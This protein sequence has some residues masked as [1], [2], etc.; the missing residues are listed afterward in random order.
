MWKYSSILKSFPKNF[1]YCSSLTTQHDIDTYQVTLI[2][3]FEILGQAS[4]QGV[5]PVT[6][7]HV[8]LAQSWMV[9]D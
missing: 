3:I 5:L 6:F 1:K 2:D 4:S 8:S 9:N 7:R